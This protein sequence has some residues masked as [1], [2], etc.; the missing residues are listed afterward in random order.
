MLR[1]AELAPGFQGLRA[2]LL[3]MM[4]AILERGSLRTVLN[5]PPA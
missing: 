3:S 2:P 5:S 4:A 1:T